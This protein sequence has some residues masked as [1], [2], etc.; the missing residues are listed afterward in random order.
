MTIPTF[1]L[2]SRRCHHHAQLF[3][4]VQ[5]VSLDA[6]GGVESDGD[7]RLGRRVYVLHLRVAAR[8]RMRQLRG[9]Q[10]AAPQRCV[11][12]GRKSR[13]AGMFG[14]LWYVAF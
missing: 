11:Q 7:E 9:P 5:R 4:D 8:V 13:H 6:A 10:T 3:H 14:G 12:A 1:S 2:L